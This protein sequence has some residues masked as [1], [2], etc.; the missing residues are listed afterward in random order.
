[1][2]NM[3]CLNYWTL[4]SKKSKQLLLFLLFVVV[5]ESIS[6][7]DP[8]INSG[9]CAHKQALLP[10]HMCTHASES[11]P[12]ILSNISFSFIQYNILSFF[13]PIG[14]FPGIRHGGVTGGLV[15]ALT[16]PAPPPSSAPREACRR[17]VPVPV[18]VPCTH[19]HTPSSCMACDM[20]IHVRIQIVR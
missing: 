20:H 3:E 14:L 8:I 1:M 4:N 15:T 12:Y 9:T 7:E 5:S 17:P 2:E 11:A 10:A 13:S 19:S 6:V 16:A 18:P